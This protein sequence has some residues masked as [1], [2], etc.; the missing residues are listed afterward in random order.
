MRNVRIVVAAIPLLLS[1]CGGG[2]RDISQ[3]PWENHPIG[4]VDTSRGTSFASDGAG[5]VRVNQNALRALVQDYARR[6]HGPL[7]VKGTPQDI[8]TTAA[9]LSALG[10]RAESILPTAVADEKSVSIRFDA[11]E[12][13]LPECGKYKSDKDSVFAQPYN[14]GSSELGCAL[15]RNIGLMIEDPADLLHARG[16]DTPLPATPFSDRVLDISRYTA[17][18]APVAGTNSGQ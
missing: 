11:Y 13:K 8:A 17:P 7:V 1:A 2:G 15:Q 4:V 12:A 10:V 14:T 18:S 5:A 6:G 9:A 3:D 16:A